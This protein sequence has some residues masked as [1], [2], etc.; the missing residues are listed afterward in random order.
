MKRNKMLF[1]DDYRDDY[2]K[3]EYYGS[4]YDDGEYEYEDEDE[5]DYEEPVRYR[6]RGRKKK[7]RKSSGRHILAPFLIMLLLVMIIVPGLWIYSQLHRITGYDLGDLKS[8]F[9]KEVR[10]SADSGAMA[11]YTNIALF[12]VDSTS[13]S[14]DAG[15]N[16]TDV[17]IIASINDKT[18]DIKLVSV[19]R[20]TYLDIGDGNYQ[21][22]NAAYAFGG[23]D[24]AVR[25]LNTNLDLN[26][27]D[28]VTVGFEG[29]A[30][31]I[32]A[33]GGIEMDVTEEEIHFLNDYQSTMAVEL[34]REYVPLTAPGPQTLNGL[35]ATAYCRIRYTDGGDFKRTERQKEVLQKAFSKVKSAG[36]IQQ[37][38]IAKELLS[39]MRTSLDTGDLLKLAM[40]AGSFSIGE[41][42]GFPTDSMRDVGY[43]GDQSCV[44]PVSLA[45]NVIWL[46]QYLFGE[47]NYQVSETVQAISD[48]VRSVSGR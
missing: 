7:K 5:D 14:L 12:G 17:M 48:H 32:D 46:H 45:D 37:A 8:F 25:M 47:E 38:A 33:V 1:E 34:G 3:E 13:E 24:Q 2:E 9:S 42:N 40:K 41:T 19:Y 26:I 31:L 23:P 18:G 16:R 36:P 43:I 35:Q 29:I 20:D 39:K 21:K 28:Y 30:T 22:A 10:Q 11:G 44:I 27:T 15:N 6:D 4:R